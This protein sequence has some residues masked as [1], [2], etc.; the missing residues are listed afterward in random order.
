MKTSNKAGD[1][2]VFNLIYLKDDLNQ[3]QTWLKFKEEF[4]ELAYCQS[5]EE[6]IRKIPKYMEIPD[7]IVLFSSWE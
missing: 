4:P 2:K 7:D 1:E 3:E 5:E 6:L